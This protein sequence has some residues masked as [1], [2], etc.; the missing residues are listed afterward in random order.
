M[1]FVKRVFPWFKALGRCVRVTQLLTIVGVMLMLAGCSD[2]VRA[3]SPEQL[4]AFEQAGAIKP[5]VDMDR[6]QKAKLKTGPYRV[7]PGDVLE[8]TMPALL[9]AVTTAEVQA[10]QTR[11]QEDYPYLVR[12][13]NTGMIALPAVGQIHV[14]GQSLAEIE[15]KVVEAYKEYAVLHPSVFVRVSEHR[16]YKVYIAG[17]V[18]EPGVYTLQD[19]Q[20]TLSYLLTQAG[21]IADAGAA[22]V[23]I[24]RSQDRAADTNT[25]DRPIILPVV[26]TNIPYRDMA[27]EEGDTVV[28][29]QIQ[30]PLFSVLGLV[31][32]PGN[33]E[34]P[35][36]AQYN[37][38]Q[39]IA[40]AGGLD[41]VADP[42]Y[43]TVYRLNEDGTIVRV[44]FRLVE[45]DELTAALGAPIRPGD[46]VAVEHTPRTRANTTIHNL[47]RINMGVYLTGRDL[48]DRD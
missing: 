10:A 37:L 8:F 25:P 13:D 14:G 30:M 11:R 26:N 18:E 46:V 22:M 23:R 44:A 31:S 32:K 27:L 33:F 39:A 40:F 35:P 36:A 41:P 48:W 47:L 20:M 34:Y 1:N 38:A 16:T 12:V 15:S 7:V 2:G 42:R 19:D 45:E 43:V 29:E 17:A 6:I 24:L 5:T 9:Q 4:A 28:V 3:P 21:G